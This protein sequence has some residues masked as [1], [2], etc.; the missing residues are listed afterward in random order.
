M[1]AVYSCYS[2]RIFCVWPMI[3]FVSFTIWVCPSHSCSFRSS[4]FSLVVY[5]CLWISMMSS[6]WLFI[7]PLISFIA[8]FVLFW[9]F[10]IISRKYLTVLF[11][12]YLGLRLDPPSML[13]PSWSES[14]ISCLFLFSFMI[15]SGTLGLNFCNP[16]WF[17]VDLSA[18]VSILFFLFVVIPG[19]S[20]SFGFV[21]WLVCWSVMD[22]F[23]LVC[24]CWI[25][26]FLGGRPLF[27]LWGWS[28]C[29]SVSFDGLVSPI[30]L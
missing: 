10:S 28:T 4:I 26:N 22:Y 13:I 15:S 3:F 5:W 18:G 14:V 12:C 27:G 24:S 8:I 23:A 21:F 17:S 19:L 25:R 29:G 30:T 20:L 11:S 9:I 7:I 2:C 1:V 6:F 16:C